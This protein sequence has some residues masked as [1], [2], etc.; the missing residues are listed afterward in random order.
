MTGDFWRIDERAGESCRDAIRSEYFVACGVGAFS[1]GAVLFPKVVPD[2]RERDVLVRT[3]FVICSKT[4]IYLFIIF[5]IMREF[6]QN[7]GDGQRRP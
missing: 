6:V 3:L 7:L 5:Y 4:G 2:A 1:L